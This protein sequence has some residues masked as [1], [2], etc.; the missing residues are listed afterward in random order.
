MYLTNWTVL[1]LVIVMLQSARAADHEPDPLN[2]EVTNIYVRL[3][4][5][6]VQLREIVRQ[7]QIKALVDF[8]R[9][10][11][12][13]LENPNPWSSHR[14]PAFEL[15]KGSVRDAL[16]SFFASRSVY[17][18]RRGQD[19]I[20]II[21]PQVAKHRNN[22]VIRR[23][24]G[25]AVIAQRKSATSFGLG[26]AEI[27]EAWRKSNPGWE[28]QRVEASID[29]KSDD[30]LLGVDGNLTS[31]KPFEIRG[32]RAFIL[33][34]VKQHPH[35]F[36]LI[37]NQNA[38]VRQGTVVSKGPLVHLNIVLA[39]W[40][41]ARLHTKPSALFADLMPGAQHPQGYA[42]SN[43]RISDGLNAISRHYHFSRDAVLKAFQSSEILT[44]SDRWPVIGG[45]LLDLDEKAFGPLIIRHFQSAPTDIKVKIIKDR[46]TFPSLLHHGERYR[47][48]YEN[49]GKGNLPELRQEAKTQLRVFLANERWRQDRKSVSQ[50][51]QIVRTDEDG[52]E[53]NGGAFKELQEIGTSSAARAVTDFVYND[54]WTSYGHG[55]ELIA[56]VVNRI[57]EGKKAAIPYL[58]ASLEKADAAIAARIHLTLCSLTGLESAKAIDARN[59]RR[60]KAFWK[61]WEDR[62]Q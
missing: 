27:E 46:W 40:N 31:A 45:F 54:A 61:A 23:A 42:D 12:E 26:S 35:T 38:N 4:S 56:Y 59:S 17:R 51:A 15:R 9:N 7:L 47:T 33:E 3:G 36:V 13:D 57:P 24:L 16:N 49:L 25:K 22:S 58:I 55:P 60:V 44:K 48:F 37:N 19:G 6:T 1:L 11:K 28:R 43:R 53:P 29:D 50:M 32:V 20:Q 21:E 30:N 2:R 18:W 41:P 39:S 14:W 34:W 10:W 5:S 52:I 8:G 62:S